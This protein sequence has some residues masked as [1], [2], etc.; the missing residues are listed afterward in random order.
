M[1]FVS[2]CSFIG[3][4]FTDFDSLIRSSLSR[5]NTLCRD[6]I[7]SF[8]LPKKIPFGRIFLG[9]Q[10][11]SVITGRLLDKLDRTSNESKSVKENHQQYTCWW[12]V[13]FVWWSG[14]Q[15]I[16]CGVMGGE[17]IGVTGCV[18]GS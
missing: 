13:V 15:A 10:K 8:C 18:L 3:G 7:E 4:S 6:V 2:L 1:S 11:D 16:E 12:F 9:R 5:Q 14:I 17:A